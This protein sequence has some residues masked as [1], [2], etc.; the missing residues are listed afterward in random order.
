MKNKLFYFYIFSSLLVGACSNRMKHPPRFDFMAPEVVEAKGFIVPM[1]RTAT[2]EIY[3]VREKA[4]KSVSKP[5]VIP[6]HSTVIP[7]G[8]PKVIAAKAPRICR[9]GR[10][11]FS[12]PEIQML[13]DSPFA[14]GSPDIS[15][16][17]DPHINNNSLES[18][19]SF[20]VQ[21]GLKTNWV[22]PIIQDKAGNLWISCAEGGVSRYDGRTFTNYT[23]AQGM[24]S[25]IVLSLLEDR[26][27]NIWLGT[28]NGGLNKFDGTSF[29]HFTIHR[30][31]TNYNVLCIA[32]DKKGDIWFGTYS[33][34]VIKFDGKTLTHYTTAQG[35]LSNTIH[36]ITTDKKGNIWLGTGRGVTKF[37]DEE[38]FTH[39]SHEQGL[40]ID[41]VRFIAED[42][43]DDLWICTENDG[44]TKLDVN[45]QS[46]EHYS[47]EQGLC[48]N[49]VTCILE[50]HSGNLWLGTE[51]KGLIKFDGASFT[52]SG[53]AQGLNSNGVH[54]IAEDKTGNLW[55]GTD[56][57]ICKYQVRPFTHM[58]GLTGFSEGNYYSLLEDKAGNLWAGIRGGGL[59]KFDG[60]SITHYAADQGLSK[61][62]VMC[63]LEDGKNLWIGTKPGGLTKYNGS[64]FMKVGYFEPHTAVFAALKDRKGNI[65]LA[66]NQGLDKYDGKKFT[67]FGVA[68]GLS[69][70]SVT[71]ICEDKKGDIWLGMEYDSMLN[72]LELPATDT[73]RYTITHY[74][75]HRGSISSINCIKQDKK[76]NLWFATS[77]AGVI[78]FDGSTFTRYTSAQGLSNNSVNSIVEDNGENMW[79]L[80][81]NGLCK[82]SAQQENRE[83]KRRPLQPPGSL[84]T[85]YL[86]ADGFLGIGGQWNSL[87]LGRDGNIWAGTDNRIT[88]YHPEMDAPDTIAPKIQLSGISLFGEN[89]N[90]LDLKKKGDTTVVLGNGVSIHDAKFAQLSKWYN[91]PENLDL[92]YNNNYLTFKFVGITTSK[93]RQVR[94]QY[95]LEGLDENWSPLSESPYATYSNLPHGSYTLKIRA[96]NGDG[97]WSDALSYPFNIRPPWWKTWWFICIGESSIVGLF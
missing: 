81:Y 3:P 96:V 35:L 66:T 88:I 58:N 19:S 34:G 72:K 70:E 57:G 16:A 90:W 17:S 51:D 36:G 13:I 52:Q 93:P 10:D 24:S 39:Y 11:G 23:M 71:N 44:V 83:A 60:K 26:K 69:R 76:N 91:V 7:A 30:G 50:D 15:T 2:P 54:S 95:R 47:T 41:S 79:F 48:S 67:H 53:I 49:Q 86:F 8:K 20:K 65:W 94:Y 42:A 55:I 29:T 78:K 28:L 59:N 43:N 14:A 22:F 37:D 5:K 33:Q 61:N 62:E 68:Q 56:D 21:Q 9:P 92:A 75:I 82:M 45:A 74:N 25:D 18:F 64:S 4:F 87:I 32:E 84:F 1:A 12:L 6:V 40:V 38:K 63:L 80:T 97:R 31:L 85:N 77:N 46:F 89:I 27:G 73:G